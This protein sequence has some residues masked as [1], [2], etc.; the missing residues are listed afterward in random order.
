MGMNCVVCGADSRVVDT[1]STQG[2]KYL[3]R[4]HE[5]FGPQPHR[6]NSLQMPKA[7]AQ[8][9]RKRKKA[10]DAASKMLAEAAAA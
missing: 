2:G 10:M 9:L 4:R 3:T 5:C 6:F 8:Q 7:E 1:R